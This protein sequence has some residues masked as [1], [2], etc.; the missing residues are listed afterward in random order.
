MKSVSSEISES[1]EVT[2]VTEVTGANE[3]TEGSEF[4]EI[5]VVNEV[6][7]CTEDIIVNDPKFLSSRKKWLILFITTFSGMLA[8][9]TNTILYPALIQLREEFDI[10]EIAVNSLIS[11]SL[12][13][14]GIAPIVWAA[15]SD[16]FATRRKV[17]LLSCIVFIIPTILCSIAERIWVLMILCAIQ[18]CGTS[19]MYS[20]GAG[21]ISD[22]YCTKERGGA[23]GIFYLAYWFSNFIGTLSGGY[24]IQYLNWHWI[25]RILAIYGGFIFPFIVF[26]VPETFCQST[27]ISQS[28]SSQNRFNPI[29]PLKLLAYPN[30]ILVVIYVSFVSSILTIQNISVP[31]NFS[32]RTYKLPPS[33]IGLLFLAPAVGYAIG[34]LVGGKYSDFVLQSARK[35]GE[36]VYPEMRIK[37]AIIGVIIIPSSY[38]A[39]GWLLEHDFNI[40]LLMIL[41]F[42]GAFGSLITFNSL[43]TY[44]VDVCPGF[45]AS[46]VALINC[47]RLMI[48]GINAIV[49]SLLENAIGTGWFFTVI[50]MACF[51]LT[52]LLVIVYFKGRQWQKNFFNSDS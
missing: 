33:S 8:P 1:T 21:I 7:E 6:S 2:E 15:Y 28:K 13:F 34:S 11:V 48:A 19:G 23:F 32:A 31:R 39:Y 25:F 24:I 16:R 45:S 26:F 18:A 42:L 3:D 51:I 41:W 4:T 50:S 44:L 38:L 14:T 17:Y 20:I 5:T 36:S 27:L 9:M 40:Y 22:I 30:V 46:V 29:A 37:S 10:S 35:K 12:F 47:I 52:F 43:S 49:G